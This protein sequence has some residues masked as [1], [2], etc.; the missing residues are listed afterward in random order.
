MRGNLYPETPST[1]H[2]KNMWKLTI[3]KAMFEEYLLKLSGCI[4][5]V[6]TSAKGLSTQC[7]CTNS[8]WQQGLVHSL[9]PET[10]ISFFKYGGWT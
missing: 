6:F 9:T 1:Q 8:R 2:R 3:N 4:G 10:V 7:I 5:T